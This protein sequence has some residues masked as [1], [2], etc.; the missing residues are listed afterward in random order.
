[1]TNK[2]Y[3]PTQHNTK[4]CGVLEIKSYINPHHI[5][6]EFTTTG[7]RVITT[8]QNIKSGNVID[9]NAC[10]YYGWGY[11]GDGPANPRTVSDNGHT[12]ETLSFKLWKSILKRVYETENATIDP[13]FHNFQTFAES[14]C[15]T[16]QIT[17]WAKAP[18]RWKLVAIDNHFSPDTISFYKIGDK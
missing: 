10:I 18:K 17:Q 8:K 3:P 1:M 11:I 2:Y 13:V 7:N 15:Q 12:S 4:K 14:L 16:P 9:P 6:V 5:E